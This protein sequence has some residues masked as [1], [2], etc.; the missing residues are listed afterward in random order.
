MDV[1]IPQTLTVFRCSAVK[2][3]KQSESQMTKVEKF[4]SRHEVLS[5]LGGISNTT[6]WRMCRAKQ[7][8]APVQISPGR[9]AWRES[10]FVEWSANR[11]AA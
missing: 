5:H 4:L 3:R 2:P 8:P 6:L 1:P 10:D 11:A 9:K 7:F